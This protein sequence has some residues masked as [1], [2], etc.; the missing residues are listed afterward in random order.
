MRPHTY[1]NVSVTKADVPKCR[2][3]HWGN[4]ERNLWGLINQLCANS[5]R[6]SWYSMKHEIYSQLRSFYVAKTAGTRSKV[7]NSMQLKE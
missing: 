5:C 1:E 7:L 6:P 3:A 4:G 2:I